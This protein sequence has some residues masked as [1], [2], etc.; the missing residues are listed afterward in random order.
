MFGTTRRRLFA[1]R[2]HFRQLL[3][4]QI[5]GRPCIARERYRRNKRTSVSFEALVKGRY[6][7]FLPVLHGCIEH[8][9][10]ANVVRNDAAFG[11]RL[12]KKIFFVNL[13]GV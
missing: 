2:R 5:N 9:C 1:V 8:Y 6:N 10:L 11:S 3:T 12:E 4:G 7:Y 13:S